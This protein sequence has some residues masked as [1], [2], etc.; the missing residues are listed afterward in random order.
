MPR[1]DSYAELDRPAA[2][3]IAVAVTGGQVDHNRPGPSRRQE[4]TAF[5]RRTEAFEGDN[6]AD[7]QPLAQ[8]LQRLVSRSAE[9]ATEG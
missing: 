6:S 9:K 4:S 8:G 3:E 7:A 2:F 5:G 1:L